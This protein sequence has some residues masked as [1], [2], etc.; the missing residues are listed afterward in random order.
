MSDV[1]QILSRIEQ[2]DPAATDQLLPLVY[3]ELRKL[4]ATKLAYE[5]PGQSLQ[6]TALVHEAYLRIVGSDDVHWNSKGHFFAAAGEAMRRILIDSARRKKRG[7]HG[8]DR[9]RIE[10][11]SA[12]WFQ[13]DQSDRLLDLDDALNRLEEVDPQKATLVKLRFFG[14]LSSK[15][16]AL[17]LRVQSHI[18]VAAEQA[19]HDDHRSVASLLEKILVEFLEAAGYLSEGQPAQPGESKGEPRAAMAARRE[20]GGGAS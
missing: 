3:D 8:G 15:D 5:K 19:A 2:G 10:L 16:A 1:T 13:C 4:A 20:I 12:H 7:K 6:A 11:E 17:A 18:K 9:Q 14:G